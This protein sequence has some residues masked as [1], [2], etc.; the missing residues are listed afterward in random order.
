MSNITTSIWYSVDIQSD[1]A[2]WHENPGQKLSKL[3]FTRINIDKAVNY[4]L[5]TL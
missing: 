5:Q 4:I 2:A 1:M 3:Y